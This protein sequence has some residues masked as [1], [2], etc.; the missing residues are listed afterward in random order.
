VLLLQAPTNGYA[1]FVGGLAS[2]TTDPSKLGVRFGM[3]CS[4]LAF[5]SLAGPPTAGALIQVDHGGFLKAQIWA[6]SVTMCAALFVSAALWTQI[7]R[8][9][10]ARHGGL[11]G[12]E[13]DPISSEGG[14]VGDGRAE[15]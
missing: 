5:A 6:G 11:V 10:S 13:Q 4:I 9:R 12:E 14:Q 3:V 8:K 7:R 2:L 1:V 15:A